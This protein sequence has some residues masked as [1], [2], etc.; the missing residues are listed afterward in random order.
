MDIPKEIDEIFERIFDETKPVSIFVYGSKA[1]GD[2]EKESDYEVGVLYG[3]GKYVPRR[4]L[5]KRY[6]SKDLNLYPFIYEDFT[7]YSLDTPFPKA[8]YIRELIETANTVRGEDVVGRM[9]QPEIKISDLL[10]VGLFHIGC[11]FSA[12]LSSRQDDWVTARAGFTKSALYGARALVILEKQKF[13]LKYEEIAEE[14]LELNLEP[15]YKK[16]IKHA[17]GARKGGEIDPNYLY[18]NISF[19]NKVV[20][21]KIKGELKKGDRVVLEGKLI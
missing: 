18:T 8:V 6:P 16:L 10:E 11:A 9:E 5:K 17:I 4:E 12:V 7:N 1:R 19:L 13:P 3:K 21:Q 15:I 2:F 14:A 20:V